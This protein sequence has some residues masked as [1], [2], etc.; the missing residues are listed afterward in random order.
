MD[1]L[2]KGVGIGR[3][4]GFSGPIMEEY[5]VVCLLVSIMSDMCDTI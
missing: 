3:G 2:A 4:L 1:E 5:C